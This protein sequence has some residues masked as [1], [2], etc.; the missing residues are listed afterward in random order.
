MT[1]AELNHK[2]ECEQYRKEIEQIQAKCSCLA[3]KNGD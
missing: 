3:L 1:E 2:A